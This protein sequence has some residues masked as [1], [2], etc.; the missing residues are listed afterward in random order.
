[1]PGVRPVSSRAEPPEDSRHNEPSDRGGPTAPD[2]LPSKPSRPAAG[3]GIFLAFLA[4]AAVL[5]LELLSLRLVAPYVGLTIQA[6]SAVI[7]MA[8]GGIAA[9]AW[10]GGQLAD[11]RN[12]RDLL[13]PLFLVAGGLAIVVLP[14][15]RLLGESVGSSNPAVVLLMAMVA[16]FLP[17]TALSAVPPLVVKQMLADLRLTGTTVGLVSAAG[18]IGGLVATFVTGFLLVAYFPVRGLVLTIAAVLLVVGVSLTVRNRG[19]RRAGQRSVLTPLLIIG[20][21]VLGGVSLAGTPR[22]DVETAYHC[23]RLVDASPPAGALT[24]H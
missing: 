18:T 14:L 20:A 6:N 21:L 13:G 2:P 16:V 23:A 5:T 1:M 3:L 24:L 9:G 17:A 4:S 19:T 15:V 7:G 22:C 12:P 11:S 10:L 8:L